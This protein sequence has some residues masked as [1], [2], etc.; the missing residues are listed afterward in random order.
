[1]SSDLVPQARKVANVDD[2][3][4]FLDALRKHWDD[5][6]ESGHII[7]DEIR[8]RVLQMCADGHPDAAALSREVLVTSTWDVSRWHA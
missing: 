6:P 7:D 2:L 3:R 5:D 4:R 8:Q 1:V